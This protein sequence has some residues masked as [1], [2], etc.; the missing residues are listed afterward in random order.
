MAM[1]GENATKQA[2]KIRAEKKKLPNQSENKAF[3]KCRSP[4]GPSELPLE[5]VSGTQKQKRKKLELQGWIKGASLGGNPTQSWWVK[6]KGVWN[7]ATIKRQRQDHR[8][9]E[10]ETVRA[11]SPFSF[12]G[13]ER[14]LWSHAH[15]KARHWG[16]TGE[17]W[18]R[19]PSRSK[20]GLVVVATEEGG[21]YSVLTGAC[22]DVVNWTSTLHL[23]P[24]PQK[25]KK[26]PPPLFLRGTLMVGFFLSFFLLKICEKNEVKS[27][28]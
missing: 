15:R 2:R 24:H 20:H 17:R 26:G 28:C 3:Q 5:T 25:P 1:H 4:S 14:W 22:F 8:N 27:T 13:S 16:G 11:R 9:C 19:I 21:Y 12:T 23:H 18:N 10:L 6:A 7:C